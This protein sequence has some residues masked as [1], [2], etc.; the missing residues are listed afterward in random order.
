VKDLADVAVGAEMHVDFVAL[1]FC[2]EPGDV[3]ALRKVLRE[4]GSQA[5]IVAKI[6]DQLAVKNLHEIIEI[7]DM[8]DKELKVTPPTS[9]AVSVAF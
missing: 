8:A 9:D 1:S 4:H 2:R 7:T 3:D 5:R 6:E